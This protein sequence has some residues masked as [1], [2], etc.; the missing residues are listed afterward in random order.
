MKFIFFEY[1]SRTH[2]PLFGGLLPK[3]VSSFKYLGL[4]FNFN[5]KFAIGIRQLKEQGRKAMLSLLRKS[6]QLELPLSTQLELFDRLVVPILT[7]SCE[8]W[9]Y[10]GIDIIESLHLEYCKYILRLKKSTPNCFVYG[11]TGHFPL[12]IHVYSRMINFWHKLTQDVNNKFSSCI[13]FTTLDCLKY[14]VFQSEWL[15][16]IKS[17]LDDCGLSFV[18]HNP[19]TV[20][21][22]WLNNAVQKKLKDMFIQDWDEKCK[23]CS[24]ACNYG[25]FKSEFGFEK[26]LDALPVTY[27]INLTKFRTSNHKL[28]IEKGRY[29]NLP[30]NERH[31][32]LCNSDQVGDEY[33][34]LLECTELNEL[35]NAHI[36]RYYTFRPNFHKYAQLMSSSNRKTRLSLCKYI[37]TGMKLFK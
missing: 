30:R 19:H 15:L 16:K 5:G 33:H 6:R 3:H 34:F 17:I 36:P 26:Y 10:S 11:E 21:T 20:K 18:W 4:T 22:N 24:K 7:Y 32:T 9:G 1:I 13:L 23:A 8:V 2:I 28:P 29:S 27:Q 14:K 12:Y 25:L 37:K 31:C 35:R